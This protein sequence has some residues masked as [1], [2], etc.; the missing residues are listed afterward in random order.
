MSVLVGQCL[1]SQKHSHNLHSFLF[2]H[3]NTTYRTTVRSVYS[4]GPTTSST[5]LLLA[6]IVIFLSCTTTAD[7]QD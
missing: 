4:V 5:I 7:N 3:Q 6:S 2:F 1:S